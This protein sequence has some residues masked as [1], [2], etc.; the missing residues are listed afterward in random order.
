MAKDWERGYTNLGFEMEDLGKFSPKAIF[1]FKT[2]AMVFANANFTAFDQK[3][4]R[5]KSANE[6]LSREVFMFDNSHKFT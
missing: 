3:L 1:F 6:S 5:G 4:D 2:F